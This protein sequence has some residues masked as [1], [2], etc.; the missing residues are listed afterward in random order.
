MNKFVMLFLLLQFALLQLSGCSLAPYK[1]GDISKNSKVKHME[2]KSIEDFKELFPD[3]TFKHKEGNIF[4]VIFNTTGYQTSIKNIDLAGEKEVSIKYYRSLVHK[5]PNVSVML[6]FPNG[7]KYP[8]YLDT[9]FPVNILLTSDIV[10]DNKFPIYPIKECTFQGICK[11]P[12]MSIGDIKIEDTLVFYYEQ[13]WQLRVLNIPLYSH[14]SIILG[15]DFI[16]SFDYVLFD[17]VNQEVVFS[18]DKTFTPDNPDLWQSYPFEIKPDSIKNNRIMVQIPING[19]EYELFFDT[20]GYKPG[21]HLNQTHWE[22]IS[23]NLTVKHLR[24]SHNLA[25]QS[26]RLHCRKATVSELS[27]GEKKIK[28][29]KVVISDDADSLSMFSLGYFQDTTVVLDFVKNLLWIKS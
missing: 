9:G 8:A 17:N 15:I 14:P 6:E 26:G 18:K 4:T 5:A 29:A 22:V 23:K 19:R 10:L 7:N 25:W 12:E 20:C 27:I 3:A 2:F 28:N 16:K 21:L 13:Q 1:T 11:I 24:K